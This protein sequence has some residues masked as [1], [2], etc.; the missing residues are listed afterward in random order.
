MDFQFVKK[1]NFIQHVV[2]SR[3]NNI[4]ACNGIHL[5]TYIWMQGS[6]TD[7]F[8]AEFVTFDYKPIIMLAKN[9]NFNFLQYVTQINY[10]NMVKVNTLFYYIVTWF[11]N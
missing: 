10:G 5:V 2:K 3:I 4:N 7:I 11:A 8:I 6:N 1:N 9:V